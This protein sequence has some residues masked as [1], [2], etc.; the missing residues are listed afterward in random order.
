MFN[1]RSEP[2]GTHLEVR[3]RRD[4]LVIFGGFTALLILFINIEAFEYVVRFS[5]G[6]ESWELDEILTAMMVLPFA[7]AIFSIRRLREAHLELDW[8]ITAEERAHAMAMHDPLTGLANRRNLTQALEKAIARADVSPLTL[9]LIDLNRFKAINDLHGHQ[10]GDELLIESA[11]RLQA[12]VG[13][14]AIVSRLGGDEFVVLL[15]DVANS[16]TILPRIEEISASFDEP[17]TLNSGSVSMGASIGATTV[18]TSHISAGTVLSQADA[19]MYKAKLRRSNCFH[20]FEA[21]MEM[22]AIR[23]AEIESALRKAI[24]E[25]RIE[26]HYQPLICLKDNRLIGYEVLARWRLEDGSL[27]MPDDFIAIAEETGLIGDMFYGLVERAA[28]DVRNWSPELTFA[29]NVSPVQFSDEWLVERILQILTKAGIAPGRLEIEITENALVTDVAMARTLIEEFK[30]QGIRVALD[31]FGTGYSSLR[32]LS[33]LDFDKLKIDRSFI[34]NVAH[35]ESSQTIV[36]TITSMA[37]NLGLQVVV[38]GVETIENALS[39][40]GY[41]CDIGQGFL[42]GKPMAKAKPYPEAAATDEA[43]D[44]DDEDGGGRLAHSA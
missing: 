22:A 5:D 6:H 13:S 11:K 34:H 16:E 23:R 7:M 33:E 14:N 9:L 36:R 4:A 10:A 26:P 40:M 31:D 44:D 21:G 20:F 28:A 27:R 39:V 41:G 19:A 37:H 2:G 43:S 29:M 15:K 8:R 18:D 3:A 35:N 24:D 12:H 30:K 42:Y 17:F 25:G 1:A 32:H 38:E